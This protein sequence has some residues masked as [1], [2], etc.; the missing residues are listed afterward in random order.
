MKFQINL[1][2]ADIPFQVSFLKADEAIQKK[3]NKC[4]ENFI[5]PAGTFKSNLSRRK[6]VKIEIDFF[7][8]RQANSTKKSQLP[9]CKKGMFFWKHEDRFQ[10][11]VDLQERKAKFTCLKSMLYINRVLRVVCSLFIISHKGVLL[12]ASSILRNNEGYVFFG[13]QAAGKSTIIKLLDGEILSDDTAILLPS[14]N[15]I[16]IFTSPF[17]PKIRGVRNL[18]AE[19]KALFL[20]KKGKVNRISL[21]NKTSFLLLF[22][23]IRPNLKFFENCDILQVRIFENI[24]ELIK[25]SD[26]HNLRFRK[27]LMV[28]KVIDE[29]KTKH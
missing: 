19:L 15:K 26:I 14:G 9:H 4:Y 22:S 17:D 25:N 11:R 21:I 16:Y 3:I 12:H 8:R 18:K 13:H 23:Y 10:G 5:A 29:F 6:E 24:F 28:G 1:L 2:I 27:N 7:K 20:L